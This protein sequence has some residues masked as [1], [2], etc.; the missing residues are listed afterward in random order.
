LQLAAAV[1]TPFAQVAVRQLVVGKT[2]VGLVPLHV[3]MHESVP[4]HAGCPVRGIGRAG[5]PTDPCQDRE[6]T[7]SSGTD[8]TKK[9]Q[10]TLPSVNARNVYKFP[11]D[12]QGITAGVKA[13]T[14][15]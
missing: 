11:R 10:V 12:L 7:Q 4:V 6:H 15:A 14:V 1:A 5:W 13:R 8:H 9:T 2:Q 3:A